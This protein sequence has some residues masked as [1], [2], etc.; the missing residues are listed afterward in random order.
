MAESTLLGFVLT[1]RFLL[2]LQLQEPIVEARGSRKFSELDSCDETIV[3][4]LVFYL[5]L[6]CQPR[7][8]G[9]CSH[10]GIVFSMECVFAADA[11]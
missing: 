1:R 2:L 8:T 9:S 7:R 5:S 11:A 3:G 4:G 6:S 10:S